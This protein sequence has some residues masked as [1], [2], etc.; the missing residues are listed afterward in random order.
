[1]KYYK[2]EKVQAALR[3]NGAT[4][5]V[6]TVLHTLFVKPIMD[7]IERNAGLWL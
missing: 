5:E 6:R 7:A 1:M 2:L 4:E 3:D